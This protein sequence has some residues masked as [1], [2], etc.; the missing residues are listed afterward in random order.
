[1]REPGDP[2][3]EQIWLN[4]CQ[5]IQ[6]R[7]PIQFEPEL[8]SDQPLRDWHMRADSDQVFYYPL[9]LCDGDDLELW[10]RAFVFLNPGAQMQATTALNFTTTIDL[11][12]THE[13]QIPGVWLVS[14]I[15]NS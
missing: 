6:K 5:V 10:G 1:M 14:V 2:V 7:L 9:S 15:K 8:G 11:D 13:Y 12:I 3:F 4:W